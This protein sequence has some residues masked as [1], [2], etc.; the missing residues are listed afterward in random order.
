MQQELPGKSSND[1]HDAL[2]SEQK[3]VPF[4]PG[5]SFRWIKGASVPPCLLPANE[6]LTLR[7]SPFD[8]QLAGGRAAGWAS[9]ENFWQCFIL[10]HSAEYSCLSF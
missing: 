7:L 8:L 10:G 4:Y 3:N 1:M 9:E 5:H 6:Q 2:A